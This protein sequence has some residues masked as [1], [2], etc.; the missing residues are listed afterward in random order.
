MRPDTGTVV[1]LGEEQAEEAEGGIPRLSDAVR[2][3]VQEQPS[4]QLE[5]FASS[6]VLA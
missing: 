5:L 4:P 2:W 6:T 1:V 3:G